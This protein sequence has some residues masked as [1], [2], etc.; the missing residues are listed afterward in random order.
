[1]IQRCYRNAAHALDR[2]WTCLDVDVAPTSRGLATIHSVSASINT[3]GNHFLFR[4]F[5]AL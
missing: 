4:F 3:R 5:L 2:G 1:M